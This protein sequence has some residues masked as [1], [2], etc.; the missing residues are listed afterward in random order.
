MSLSFP[1]LYGESRYNGISFHMNKL[2]LSLFKGLSKTNEKNYS[3]SVSGKY[4]ITGSLHIRVPG[5]SPT[6]IGH[7]NCIVH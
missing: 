1:V 4:T 7:L 3:P 6:A 5:I 2:F